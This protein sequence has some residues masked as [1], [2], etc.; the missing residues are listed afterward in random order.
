MR[1]S[2]VQ[3]AAAD[4]RTILCSVSETS[5]DSKSGDA[6]N[7]SSCAVIYLDIGHGYTYD[8]RSGV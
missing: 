7:M 8:V 6:D 1:L 5:R 4:R 3:Y 2:R